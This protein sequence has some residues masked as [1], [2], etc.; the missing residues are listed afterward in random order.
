MTNS[1]DRIEK[2]L[3][4]TCLLAENHHLKH[5]NEVL[6]ATITTRFNLTQHSFPQRQPKVQSSNWEEPKLPCIFNPDR[7]MSEIFSGSWFR[8]SR[9]SR[10][11]HVHSVVPP[12]SSENDD[13]DNECSEKGGLN[14]LEKITSQPSERSLCPQW[15]EWPSDL[16]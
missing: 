4:H 14:G 11:N 7:C 16:K 15:T 5:E 13:F 10:L 2:E 3:R 12:S 1:R 8:K 6:R 9:N